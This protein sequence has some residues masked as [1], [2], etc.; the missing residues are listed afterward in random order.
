MGKGGFNED[1][2]YFAGM[3]GGAGSHD[4]VKAGIDNSDAVLWLGRFPS[5]FNTAEFTMDVPES[6]IVDM[7]RFF[8]TIGGKKVDVTMKYL[9]AALIDDIK[10]NPVANA[11]G[12]KVD[13]NPYP[14]QHPT[15]KGEALTQ[16][17]MWPAFGEFFKPDDLIIGETGTSAFGLGDSKLPKDSFMFN[18][19]IFGSIG[20]ATGAAV[21]AFTA[22]RE[23]GKF[24][25]CILVTGEGSF[26]LTAQAMADLLRYELKPIM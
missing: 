15:A 3:Y 22:A 11:A 14:L 18:Q 24:K 23:E 10:Q 9:L 26:H 1:L 17:F 2:P 16:D 13:W 20:F 5:D 4:G 6:K 12:Y 8:A 7:Q 19:T 25:R 21:G